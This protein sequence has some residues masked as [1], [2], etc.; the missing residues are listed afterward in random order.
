MECDRSRSVL[1]LSLRALN[2]FQKEKR[3]TPQSSSGTV[4]ARLVLGRARVLLKITL[5]NYARTSERGNCV[6]GDC[7][8]S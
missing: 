5:R 4:K 7:A 8:D 2:F 3:T 1:S 6:A